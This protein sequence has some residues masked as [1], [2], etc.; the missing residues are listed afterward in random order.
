MQQVLRSL[1]LPRSAVTDV[2]QCPAL[3][4]K[5]HLIIWSRRSILRDNNSY[6]LFEE[7]VS[8]IPQFYVELT[9]VCRLRIV[10]LSIVITVHFNI[11]PQTQ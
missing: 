2:T 10:T 9:R 4:P 6:L 5:G 7:E 11:S 3:S 1:A 8:E